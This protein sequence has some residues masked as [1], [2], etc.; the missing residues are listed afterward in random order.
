MGPP[1]RTAHALD[2]IESDLRFCRPHFAGHGL[3]RLVVHGR[4]LVGKRSQPFSYRLHLGQRIQV[5][6]SGV[7]GYRVVQDEDSH[8]EWPR[9][10]AERTMLAMS[11]L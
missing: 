4:D 9:S 6:R 7:G 10:M 8:L 3:R 5:I 1:R 11:S 2:K